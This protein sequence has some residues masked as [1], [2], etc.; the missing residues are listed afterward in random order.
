MSGASM[1]GLAVGLVAGAAAALL[2]TPLRGRDMRASLRSR[3]DDALDRGLRLFEGASRAFRTS[4]DSTAMTAS[5]LT[6]SLSEIAAMHSANEI[7]SLE[8]RP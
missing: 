8:A 2:A 7:S 3:A 4:P 1:M 5:P 6:A